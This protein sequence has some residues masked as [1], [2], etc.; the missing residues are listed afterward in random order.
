V[1]YYAYDARGADLDLNTLTSEGHP[2][3]EDLLAEAEQPMEDAE[4]AVS[5]GRS[6][7][8]GRRRRKTPPADAAA[9]ALSG[10]FQR[11]LAELEA[12]ADAEEA[13]EEAAAKE[14]TADKEET[15]KPTRKKRRRRRRRKVASLI[16]TPSRLYVLAKAMELKS[17]DIIA[18]WEKSG[19]EKS[20]G[21]TLNNHMSTV[22]PDQ[23]SIIQG[24]FGES[25]D[26]QEPEATEP[27]ASE[28]TDAPVDSSEESDDQL[29][30]GKRRRRR[31]GGRG[32]GRGRGRS[33]QPTSE[34]GADSTASPVAASPS[35]ESKQDEEQ[36][37]SKKKRSRRRRSSSRSKGDGETKATDSSAVEP[38]STPQA[39]EKSEPKAEKPAPRRRTLY[40]SRRKLNSGEAAGV[41]SG[42]SG[43]E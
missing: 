21:F 32:R 38:T 11:E 29:G 24:W 10:E 5:T 22:T 34:E 4:E 23:A 7:R 8:R 26:N 30:D 36:P 28:S 39:K 43:Q 19:G 14:E 20:V 9:I 25:Q 13:A 16:D 42:Q 41:L 40:G 33:S 37:A 1:A 31:R 6:P 17:K 2:K 35:Q 27:A 18:R 15:V 3:I 12:Q